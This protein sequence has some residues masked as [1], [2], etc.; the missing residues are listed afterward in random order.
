MD[1][2]IQLISFLFSLLFGMLFSFFSRYHY[3]L[4]Y[5]LKKIWQYLLSFLF[6]L[7]VSLLYILLLYYINN[8]I[9]HI[10]FLAFTIMGY[11]LEKYSYNYV[12]CHVK[13]IHLFAKSSR[14]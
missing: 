13:A 12:K 8:G 5:K 11:C 10:Y 6:I 14:K 4:V 9:V 2:K 1:Y 3:N 7:D